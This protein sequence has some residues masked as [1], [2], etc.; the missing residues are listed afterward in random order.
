MENIIAFINSPEFQTYLAA[1]TGLVT[2]ASVVTALTP[3]ESDNKVVNV[4]LRV[5]N[6]LA[7]NVGK[8]KN[9]DATPKE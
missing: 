6:V 9:A 4:I 2:A 1:I 5:L 7:L 8:N 3:T